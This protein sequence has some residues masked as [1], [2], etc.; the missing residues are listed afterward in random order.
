ME[1][2]ILLSLLGGAIFL[3]SR[4]VKKSDQSLAQ[5]D[6][7]KDEEYKAQ[8]GIDPDDEVSS[9][10]KKRSNPFIMDGRMSQMSYIKFMAVYLFLIFGCFYISN[11]NTE[12]FNSVVKITGGWVVIF[13]YIGLLVMLLTSFIASMVKRLHD[14]G[15]SGNWLFWGLI[16]IVAFLLPFILALPSGTKGSNKYGDES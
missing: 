4:M 8:T 5:L 6:R 13:I 15:Y 11:T 7:A 3:V 1:F 2:L 12:A 9:S 10:V 16:P 14:F